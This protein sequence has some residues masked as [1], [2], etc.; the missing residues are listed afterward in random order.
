MQPYG[1]Y[2]YTN[3]VYYFIDCTRHS[4]A[5]ICTIIRIYIDEGSDPVSSGFV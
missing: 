3:N 5:H 1:V 4:S 2:I